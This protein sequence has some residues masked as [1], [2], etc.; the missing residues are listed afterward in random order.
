MTSGILTLVQSYVLACGV[1]K[2]WAK[3]FKDLDRP[4]Q[5]IARLE[6]MLRD[7]G[8]TGRF[9]MAQAKEIKERR[10]LASEL[11]E[12]LVPCLLSSLTLRRRGC[13]S[14]R[15]SYFAAEAWRSR[16]AN[17]RRGKRR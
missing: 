10:E 6:S 4:S 8:M 3:E 2:A 16:Q 9:T 13:T 5:Q 15:E 14:V 12:F 7:L 17:G 1:R 11:R